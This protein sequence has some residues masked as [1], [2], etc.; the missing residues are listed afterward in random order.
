[1]GAEN[2][3]KMIFEPMD[4]SIAEDLIEEFPALDISL[5]D[6]AYLTSSQVSV[7]TGIP[8][9]TINTFRQEELL[10]PEASMK[11]VRKT[12]YLYRGSDVSRLE[13]AQRLG[14]DKTLVASLRIVQSR[15]EV[16]EQTG[17][18]IQ[19]FSDIR[20]HQLKDCE[21]KTDTDALLKQLAEAVTQL[22]SLTDGDKDILCTTIDGKFPLSNDSSQN[23]RNRETVHQ[24][25]QEIGSTLFNFIRL[26]TLD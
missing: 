22:N 8:T 21:D 25:Y 17:Q 20:E 1:M 19:A 23:V 16:A 9:S 13:D 7:L 11:G 15:E 24:A 6:P 18:L 14:T 12:I 10:F 26:A 4:S 2:S 5:P 3:G